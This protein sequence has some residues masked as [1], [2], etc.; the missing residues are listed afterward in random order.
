MSN[1]QNGFLSSLCMIGRLVGCLITPRLSRSIPPLVV[2][3]CGMIIWIVS[4]A[5]CGLSF[6]FYTLAACR[7]F[8]G[9]GQAPL[10]T[11]GTI[12]IGR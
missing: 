5:S 9:I 7:L 4:I 6:N 8:A 12:I 3:G 1:L 11:I 2:I 10:S